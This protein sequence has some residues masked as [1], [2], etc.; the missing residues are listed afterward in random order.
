MDAGKNDKR[1]QGVP[2]NETNNKYKNIKEERANSLKEYFK[3]LLLK[4]KLTYVGSLKD[5]QRLR[6]SLIDYKPEEIKRILKAYLKRPEKKKVYSINAGLSSV[7]I[8]AYQQEQA[9]ESWQY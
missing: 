9:K 2:I 4:E 3:S 7:S 8:S 1:T 6:E 5:E